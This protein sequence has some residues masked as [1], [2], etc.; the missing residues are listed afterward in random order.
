MADSSIAITAGAGTPVDTRTAPDGDHRQVVVLGD[1]T[2]ANCAEVID[3]AG[4]TV[5]GQTGASQGAALNVNPN[6][7]QKATY[8]VSADNLS[9]GALT[10]NTAKAVLSFEHPAT[11]TR[12]VRL[13]RIFM[14]AMQ[15]SAVAGS[16]RVLIFRGTAASSA[17]TT[18]TAQPA[19]PGATAAEVVCKSLPTITA[20][21]QML[22]YFG[23]ITTAAANTGFAGAVPYDWQ[24]SGETIPL[25]LRAGSLDT[26][27]ISVISSGAKTY[28]LSLTVVLTEE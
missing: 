8:V 9:S 16:D 21:T 5:A 14:G 26:I 22:A 25:T 3:P 7:V 17:G 1:E 13:R 24:E 28:S 6:A 2:T 19:V 27:V 12:T 23:S 15:T 11:A 20:A 4:F 10:A 18:V